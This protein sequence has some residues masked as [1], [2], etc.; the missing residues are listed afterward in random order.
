MERLTLV[1]TA[2]LFFVVTV[3]AQKDQTEKSVKKELTHIETIDGNDFIG[4]ITSEDEQVVKMSTEKFGEISIS[5]ADIKRRELVGKE[6][7]V[8]NNY[9]FANSNSTRYLFAPNAYALKK[10]EGYYQNTWVFM[11]QVSYGFTD[12]FTVGMGTIPLFL[13]GSGIARATPFWITPKYTFG[14]QQANKNVAAG[15]FYFFFPFAGA[16]EGTLSAGIAYGSGTIGNRNSNL[17]FGLGYGFARSRFGG[18]SE[19][20]FAK[21]PTLNLSGMYRLS[22]S[23][24]LVSENWFVSS[25]EFN[26]GLFSGAYRYC[27]KNFSIDLGLVGIASEDYIGPIAPWLGILIP[28]SR[29]K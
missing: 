1:F 7:L 2:L 17:S 9:W 16:D 29:K 13:F 18:V 28:F 24:Y 26:V 20:V 8:D 5:K 3:T 21:Y 10:G 4:K 11:N 27:G 22:K 23:G 12:K 6:Q 19:T 15:V 14:G 25:G